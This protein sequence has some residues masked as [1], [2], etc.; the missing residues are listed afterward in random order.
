MQGIEQHERRKVPDL[1]GSRNPP[2]TARAGRVSPYRP[3]CQRVSRVDQARWRRDRLPARNGVR[4]DPVRRLW[5]AAAIHGE[6]WKCLKS[7][8]TLS[9]AN[10]RSGGLSVQ[11][12]VRSRR[13]SGSITTTSLSLRVGQAMQV[14]SYV[15]S[16]SRRCGMIKFSLKTLLILVTITASGLGVWIN[17]CQTAL[18][19]AAS[20]ASPMPPIDKDFKMPGIMEVSIDVQK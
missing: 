1:S 3:T 8:R 4:G 2:D 16:L 14:Q 20:K 6:C 11:W 10:M 13:L 19:E 7:I 5:Y 18:R 15:P 17:G 12:S 9:S